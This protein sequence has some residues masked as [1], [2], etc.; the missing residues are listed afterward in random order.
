[1]ITYS[2]SILICS[3]SSRQES[4]K[5]LRAALSKQLSNVHGSTR[6]EV[7]VEIDDGAMNVG[8][9]R[10][11]LLQRAVGEYVAYIDDDDMV[12]D[13]YI[14]SILKAIE[15]GPDCVGIQGIISV[16]QNKNLFT[17]SIQYGAWY[18]G[19]DGVYYRTPNHLN[20]VRRVLALQ[21]G[22]P[23]KSNYG[24]DLI[25]SRKLLPFLETEVC[26]EHPIYFYNS[27]D[28]A[29]I[30]KRNATFSMGCV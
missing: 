26:V 27:S 19:S 11:I 18:T 9:K 1:M 22:F 4:L 29:S 17:H 16:G 23:S 28:F 13:D 10:N 12:S 8:L 7:L 14:S 3:L 6:V 2:L 20:P 21:I 25:Y 24:E 5:L 30:K 15:S